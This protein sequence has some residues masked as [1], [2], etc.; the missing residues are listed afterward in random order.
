MAAPDFEA[1][2]AREIAPW[3][4]EKEAERRAVM[5]RVL[6]CS[7]PLFAAALLAALPGLAGWPDEA[8]SGFFFFAAFALA[9][10]AVALG[11]PLVTWGQ[12]FRAELSARIFGHFGYRY[13]PQPPA[14]FFDPFRRARILPGHDRRR[15][16]D[17]VEG[18]VGHVRFELAEAHL[19]RERRR[20]KRTEY[21]TVFRGLL[22][23]YDFPKRFEG[24]TTLRADLG[25]IGNRL[26]H[27]GVEGTRVRLE[28]AAFEKAFEVF[29]TDQVEARYL[30]TPAFMERML[31][32]RVHAPGGLQAAFAEGHLW[33]AI[34]AQ[35]DLF[36][37][38]SLWRDLRQSGH[39][40]ELVADIRLI[41]DI[42][43]TLKLD[44]ETR[45]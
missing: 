2:H 7:G 16:E 6:G 23:R 27:G 31:E 3:I 15:L 20:D 42:A 45:V 38:P 5:K 28:S 11:S 9:A 25:A 21:V 13:A 34:D 12:Q 26:G 29:S 18:A 33:L 40:D 24:R 43:G 10:A 30:L 1:F 41:G 39:L 44:A 35:R 37:R 17:H 36:C 22:A 32:L 8:L 14:G 4:E 19:E